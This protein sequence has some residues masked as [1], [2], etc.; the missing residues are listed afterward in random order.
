V[1]LQVNIN[2]PASAESCCFASGLEQAA[3]LSGF[4]PVLLGGDV[5]SSGKNEDSIN[6]KA[7]NLVLLESSGYQL[8]LTIRFRAA[9]Q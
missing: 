3:L 4:C 5:S 7:G 1:Q 2:Q 9:Y 6:K 8:N